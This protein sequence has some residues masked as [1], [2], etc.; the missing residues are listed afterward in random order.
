METIKVEEILNGF[1]DTNILIIGDVMLDSYI[2]GSVSRI[3]PE[4]PVPVVAVEKRYDRLGGAANVALNIKALGANPILCSVIGNDTKGIDL[5]T[6]LRESGL[7]TSGVVLSTHRPTTTKY[8]IIGNKTQ[9]LRVDD[10]VTNELNGNEYSELIGRIK[11]L[12][13]SRNIKA[14]IFEDYDKGCITASLI[15]EIT[16]LAQEEGI[17]TTVDPKKRNFYN[18]K[19]VTLLKPNLKELAEGTGIQLNRNEIE[20]IVEASRVLMSNLSVMNIM[21]TL[22]ED[23]VLVCSEHNFVHI[24]AERRN[25]SDVSGAGDTV[26]SVLTLAMASNIDI[27]LAASIANIAG[28]LVCQQVGVVPVDSTELRNEMKRL[29]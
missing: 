10:E 29:L 2:E 6:I 27:E 16:G 19:N 20:K 24:K 26:I 4:A 7:D 17:I 22:G 5:I 9:M 25:V 1:V 18:Y 23:G 21:T 8:R 28:G 3:S 14:I 13:R 11:H 15:E 12:V